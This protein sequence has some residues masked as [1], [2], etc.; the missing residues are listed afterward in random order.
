MLHTLLSLLFS[1][2][3]LFTR[4]SSLPLSLIQHP[5]PPSLHPFTSP[6][7]QAS[8]E[9]VSE[10]QQA[11]GDDKTVEEQVP[12]PSTK[13]P[14]TVPFPEDLTAMQVDCGTFHTAVLLHSGEVYTFGNGNHGQLGQGNNKVW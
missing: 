2:S 7:A 11:S 12:V 9:D 3:P 5:L 4:T 13:K 6:I 14:D 10:D 1:L 8:S